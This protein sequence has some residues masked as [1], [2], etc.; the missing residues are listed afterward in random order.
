MQVWACET[1]CD[2]RVT[3]LKGRLL[4]RGA[5][6]STDFDLFLTFKTLKEKR[7]KCLLRF[8]TDLN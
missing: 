3:A 6:V 7:R 5:S 1:K 8:V 4:V 2:V